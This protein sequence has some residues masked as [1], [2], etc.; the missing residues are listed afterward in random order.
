MEYYFTVVTN[1]NLYNDS[2]MLVKAMDVLEAGKKVEDMLSREGMDNWG[3][4]IVEITRTNIT[5][6]IE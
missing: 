3:I 1:H 4:E 6:V 2:A 5:K